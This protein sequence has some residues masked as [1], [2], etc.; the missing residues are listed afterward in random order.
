MRLLTLY[1]L[2]SLIG[3]QSLTINLSNF[4]SLP[5]LVE[6]YK[7]HKSE[8]KNSMIEFLD[9]HYGVKKKDHAN[10]HKDHDN[11]PIQQYQYGFINFYFEPIEYF[12]IDS[13]YFEKVHHNFNYCKD[14]NF[15][16]E[17]KILQP[18]KYL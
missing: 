3:F 9:L 2:T 13:F 15:L 14:F 12:K 16:S 7:L 11:L 6:H 5:E 18:P 10:E 17:T 8:Y 4:T 1:L